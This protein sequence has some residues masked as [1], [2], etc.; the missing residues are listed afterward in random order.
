MALAKPI[1]DALWADDSLLQRFLDEAAT[2]LGAAERELIASWKQRVSGDFVVLKHL[3]KHSI[4]VSKEGFAVLGIYSPLQRFP[5]SST[6]SSSFGAGARRAFQ[7]QYR[8]AKATS[9]VRTSLQPRAQSKPLTQSARGSVHAKRVVEPRPESPKQQLRG[10]WR[11]TA[12]ELWGAD[13][14]NMIQPAFIRFDDGRLGALGMIA[15]QADLDCRYAM[16]DGK[17]LAEF[18][19]DGDDD[20]DPWLGRGW[21]TLESDGTLHGRQFIHHGDDS[22]FVAERVTSKPRASGGGVKR[23]TRKSRF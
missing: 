17:A 3:Q 1:R 4:F 9:H 14:L 7:E 8:K 2:G 20:G 5:C 11:I 10:E 12:T 16:R 6:L 15:T 13:A 22:D 18:T 19:F 21:A 23:R